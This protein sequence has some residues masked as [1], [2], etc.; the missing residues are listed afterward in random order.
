M[1]QLF[2]TILL[3]STGLSQQSIALEVVQDAFAIGGN[4]DHHL[5]PYL[6]DIAKHGHQYPLE[7]KLELK[8]LGFQFDRPLVNRSSAERAESVGLDQVYDHGLF[9]FHYTKLGYHAVDATDLNGND[10]PDYIDSMATVFNEV[11]QKLHNEMG[12]LKPPGDGYYSSTR[13]KGGSAHYDV[14]VRNLSSRYYG[15]VQPEEYA[16]GKGDNEQSSTVTE[17]NAFTSYMTMRNN[18]RSFPLPQMENIKVTAAHEYFHAIQFGYDGWEKPWL[19]ESSAVWMEE[20]LYDSINDCY[21]YMKKWFE[22]PHRALD[23]TGYHWYGSFIFFEFIEQHMGGSKMIRNI[24][25]YSVQSNSRERDGSHLAVD[26]ALSQSGHSFQQ[27]LNGMAVANKIMSSLPGAGNYAYEEAEGYPVDGPYIYKTVN[28]EV[29]KKDTLKS[30]NLDRFASQ[31]TQIV[32]SKPVQVKLNNLSNTMSDLQLNAI[33]KRSD[34][35]YLVIGSPSINID[36]VGLKSI[37]LAVVS[38]DTMGGNWDYNIA[39]EDGVPGTDA[40]L[41]QVFSLGNPY[42]NPFNGAVKFSIYM[43]KETNVAVDIVDIS[44]RRVARLHRGSLSPGNH[45]LSWHGK[46]DNG[47]SM[48]SGVYYI[49][50]IG[51]KTQEWRPITF[52]K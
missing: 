8:R 24:M 47:S 37:H 17:V 39:I 40:N 5:T 30:T 43:L 1:K 26:L 49:K 29:G 4:S 11:S 28:F 19:L 3:A 36:P 38:Q 46:S 21:Q 32:T 45:Q 44:G 10:I 7:E 27:A 41:P 42:P 9:R 15:Y 20:E 18:Y 34:N 31:Y 12:Y 6:M 2:A 25:E 22:S 51:G 48:A 35:S 13:D 52:V 16:Q 14:Y 33:L 23:E 50:A